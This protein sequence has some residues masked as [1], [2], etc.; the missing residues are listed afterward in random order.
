[1]I[2]MAIANDPDLLIADEPTTALDVTIQAQVMDVLSRAR[3]RS[4]AAM[5][6]ITHDLGLVAEAADRVAVMYGGRLL[7]TS[8]VDSIFGRTAHPYTV[9]LLGSL[10]RLDGKGRALYAIPGQPPGTQDRPTGCVFHPRCGMRQGRALCADIVPQLESVA[11]SHT[12]ACHFREEV[13]Q[14]RGRVMEET[15]PD[16]VASHAAAAN[17]DRG[18]VLRIEAL[19]K[20]FEVSNRL[21]LRHRVLHAVDGISFEIAR[22]ET[23]GL[24]GESGCGKSTLGRVILQ[25]QQ[26][27]GGSIHLNGR[28]LATMSKRELRAHRREMQ[29]VFQ[30][31]YSSLDPR[32][33]IAEVVAEPLRINRSFKAERVVEM[34]QH[35][36]LAPDALRRRPPEFSGGQRQ[37]IAIARALALGPDLLILD[38]AVSALDVSIQAQV[39]NLLMRLQQEFGLSYLFIAHDLSV[40]RHISHRVAVMYLGKIVEVGTRDQ[41]FEAPT[42]PYTQALLSAVPIPE[43]GSRGSQRRIVLSGDLPNPLDPPSG[44]SFRSR[45]FKA[46]PI[47]AAEEPPL[48]PVEE[49][50]QRAACHFPTHGAVATRAAIVAGTAHVDARHI[51][52]VD[53][54]L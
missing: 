30:D 51:D 7:E 45:C 48:L 50:G 47:C 16:N 54:L 33:T 20:T 23:L 11:P 19:R 29:V 38:E 22:G 31:P 43:A 35:V 6:M 44:C 37:R 40:V 46:A 15:V 41:V 12:S 52:G 27:S 5:V 17:S 36:G 1:M 26:A 28:N 9:G 13:P 53:Q 2:A 14:W 42:H 21:G 34:M 8:D 32:M 49:G 25:L 4:G 24:V 18:P 3:G 10:P 39:I